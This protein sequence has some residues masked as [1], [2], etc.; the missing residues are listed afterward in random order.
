MAQISR[1]RRF[2]PKAGN[3]ILA[4]GEQPIA[5]YLRSV[6]VHQKQVQIRKFLG[7]KPDELMKQM[8]EDK[9]SNEIKDVLFKNVVKF[10]NLEITEEDGSTK[11]A[12]IEDM[13]TLG[14]FELC[15]ELFT[16]ILQSSQLKAAEAKN[17]ESPSG[18]TPPSAEAVH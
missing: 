15:L 13:W 5:V 16:E 11:S 3:A 7:M 1:I 4:E 2:V 18:S 9:G 14:E 6:D 17:S 8:M 12:V 10:D